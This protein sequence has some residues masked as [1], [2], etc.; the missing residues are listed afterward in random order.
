MVHQCCLK[1]KNLRAYYYIEAQA[2]I[3]SSE[4]N[5]ALNATDTLVC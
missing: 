2:F 5:M 4:Y 3:S 1:N